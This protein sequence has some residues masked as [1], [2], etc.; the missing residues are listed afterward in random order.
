MV[1]VQ[2]YCIFACHL[3]L[4]KHVTNDRN[5]GLATNYSTKFGPLF[6]GEGH[7]TSYAVDIHDVNW[8]YE[9]GKPTFPG[10]FKFRC[11]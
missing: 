5:W 9:R 4:N 8:L 3:G 10:E 1:W 7:K 11:S 2:R 6:C